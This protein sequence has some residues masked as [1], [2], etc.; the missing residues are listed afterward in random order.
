MKEHLKISTLIKDDSAGWKR[1]IFRD[2]FIHLY[3]LYP[4]KKQTLQRLIQKQ[5]NRLIQ[6]FPQ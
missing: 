4:P 5:T 1:V 2:V 6:F 3:A